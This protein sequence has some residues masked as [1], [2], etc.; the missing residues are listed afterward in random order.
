MIGSAVVGA[1][2]IGQ[3]HLETLN[4]LPGVRAV[5]VYDRDRTQ[6]ERA[7]ADHRLGSAAES[8][9]ALLSDPAVDVVHICTPNS[10]HFDQACAALDAGKQVFCE[11]PLALTSEQGRILTEK[12]ADRGAVTGIGFCYRYYPVVQELALRVR[13][14]DFGQVR[15]VSGTWFQDWLSEAA[16]YT[17]RLDKDQSGAANVAADLGSHWFD[18]VQFVTGLK[19]SDVFADF[20][21][22]IP[23]RRKPKKQVLA[24]QAGGSGDTEPVRIDVEDYAA[25]LFRMDG[26]RVPGSFTTSQVCPG[27][28]SDTEFQVYCSEGSAAWNHKRSNELWIGRR[29]GPNETLIE[30]PLEMDGTLRGYAT[31]PAGHPLGYRDAMA[32]ML[33][34]YYRAVERGVE[35][36]GD[37]RP[38]FS[39]GY[40]E[41]LLLDRMVASRVDGSWKRV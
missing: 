23:E 3:I 30:N 4:R 26:G 41:M 10:L 8:F 36:D 29:R 35:G 39:T 9:E 24:F 32:N 18:L 34:D 1:G 31:L 11:K 38:N 5:A 37:L 7:A 22:I 14:G 19:V 40:R 27:R 13:R 21:T 33:K 6:A 12:A 2:Y 17:W 15:M 28:K 16:D 20:H 25:V